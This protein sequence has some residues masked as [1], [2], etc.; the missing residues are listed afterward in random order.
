MVR[1][2]DE[3][4]AHNTHRVKALVTILSF[5]L[6]V[7]IVLLEI[8]FL[9]DALLQMSEGKWEVVGGQVKK[10][11]HPRK[12][13]ERKKQVQLKKEQDSA[14]EAVHVP[15]LTP[16]LAAALAP[17]DKGLAKPNAN[18]TFSIG[19]KHFVLKKM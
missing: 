13:P 12:D 18:G 16:A 7:K 1:H 8:R 17:R 5:L 14:R 2:G 11:N 4:I 9:F 6:F 10:K 15:S 19:E 3:T